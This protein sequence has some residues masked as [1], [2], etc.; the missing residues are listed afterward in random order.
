MSEPIGADHWDGKPGPSDREIISATTITD[1]MASPALERWKAWETGRRVVDNLDMLRGLA[2]TQPDTAVKWVVNAPYSVPK[3]RTVNA[4]DLGSSL[5]AAL[6]AWLKGEPTPELP[7][8]AWQMANLLARWVE[9]FQPRLHAAELFV[10]NVHTLLGGRSD[11]WAWIG[12]QLWLLDLKTSIENA[13]K[14]GTLKR[15]Y[16]DSHPLQLATYRHATHA[17]TWAPRVLEGDGARRYLVNDAELAVAAP[18]PVAEHTGILYLTPQRCHLYPVKTGP[19]VY[20]A[21]Q[22]VAGT[23]RWLNYESEG[24]VGSPIPELSLSASEVAA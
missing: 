19:A 14:R 7:P 18:A 4:A 24:A 3:G 13:N 17:A 22:S 6:E 20:E 2:D 16:N 10:F 11:L 8:E 23:W 21:V 15:P 9:R 5:H 1:A 12:G